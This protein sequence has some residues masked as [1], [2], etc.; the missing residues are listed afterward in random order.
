MNRETYG[1]I[2]ENPVQL[3]STKAAM[4]YLDSLVTKN[5]AHHFLFHRLMSFDFNIFDG[6]EKT[7]DNPSLPHDCIVWLVNK[8]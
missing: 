2:P 1:L 6:V 7:P 5:E 3:N 8:T 4:A